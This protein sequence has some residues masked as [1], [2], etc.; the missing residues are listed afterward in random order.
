[1]IARSNWPVALMSNTKRSCGWML[2]LA[3]CSS[4][5]SSQC[6]P[7]SSVKTQSVSLSAP[8]LFTYCSSHNTLGG[9]PSVDLY[10]WSLS[11]GYGTSSTYSGSLALP[12]K[13]KKKIW[14]T[15]CA[16]SPD[17]S[18]T[19]L[20]FSDSLSSPCSG[21]T[22]W[23]STGLWETRILCRHKMAQLEKEN[24]ILSWRNTSDDYETSLLFT[25]FV[26]NYAIF[27]TKDMV[28]KAIF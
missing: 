23:I 25:W 18:P 20:S 17:S 16:V 10:S 15:L 12:M 28:L 27:K 4:T 7:C 21:K 9:E 6:W 22:Q 5:A 24:L 11:H 1:M 3:S 26:H 13:M 14:S 8:A 2:L 19:Y